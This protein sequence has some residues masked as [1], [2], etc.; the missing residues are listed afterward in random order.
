MK[1]RPS[2]WRRCGSR[3]FR[4]S[5]RTSAATLVLAIVCGIGPAPPAG[6]A[7]AAGEAAPMA[8][9]EERILGRE[10][11]IGRLIPITGNPLE[12]RSVDLRIEFRLDSEELTEGA[13][14]PL[15]ELGAT[16][17]SEALRSVALGVYG[18]TD[19]RGLADYNQ[20]LS[21]RRSP[22]FCASTSASR[23]PGSGR[24]GAMGRRGCAKISLPMRRPSGGWSS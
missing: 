22:A 23:A 10:A 20:A 15:L 17:T 3:G 19:S 24:C 4:P 11:L 12:I 18:H 5:A 13:T 9:N 14:A 1:E 6:A 8:Q 21:E 16:V 7:E 2:R